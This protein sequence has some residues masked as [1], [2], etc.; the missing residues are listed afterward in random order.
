MRKR[1]LWMVLAGMV[2]A[3]IAGCGKADTDGGETKAA[4]E[5]A[6]GSAGEAASS[7]E[8]TTIRFVS[9]MTGGEDK[10]YIEK[11]MEDNPDVVVEV[12]AVDGT[13]YD[14]L[15]KTRLISD[16]APDV[17]LIQP[18]QYEK[19]VKEGYLM[20]VSD[21]PTKDILAKSKSLEDLYTIDGKQYGFP[22]CTQGGP[23]PIFYNKKYFKKLNIQEPQ[24][25]DELWA[26]ADKIKEDGVEPFVFGDKDAWTFENFFRSRHF[27]DYLKDTPEWGLAL[28]NG[29]VQASDMFKKEF[30][31]AEK[32]CTEGYIGKAS[33]TMTYPQSVTYFVEGKAAML[34]QGTWVPGLDEIKNADPE[35]FE[36]GCFMTPVDETDGKVYMTGSSDRS[37]VISANTQKKEAAERLYDWFTE[38]ENLSEYL[39]SQSLTNFLPIKYEVDPVLEDYVAALSTDKYE[40]IMSQK[41]TMPAGFL[42]MMENGL[43]SILA[44]S[45]AETELQKLNTEFEK[46]KSSIVVSE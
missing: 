39:S 19:F 2:A 41:A 3:G 11:F 28:Y 31:L 16:D 6:S 24:T 1:I 29:D 14:K 34:P 42:T 4:T 21:R 33:L 25:M 44:G 15:L 5:Q 30:E 36:L 20:D 9:W 43:Q 18:A 26:A 17:F 10:A 8:Q 37:I 27:G 45:P 7:S 38:E 12:E 23:L 32:M 35:T 13:N 46:I 40:I 22:V